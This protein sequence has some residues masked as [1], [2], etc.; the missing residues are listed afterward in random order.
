MGATQPGLRAAAPGLGVGKQS[1]HVVQKS[2]G[3]L[4]SPSVVG[5]AMEPPPV[6]YKGAASRTEMIQFGLCTGLIQSCCVK[7]SRGN[8]VHLGCWGHELEASRRRPP[9]VTM[10]IELCRI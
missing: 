6:T 5:G 4:A 9:G 2:L 10:C 8:Y 1:H 7:M 3:R